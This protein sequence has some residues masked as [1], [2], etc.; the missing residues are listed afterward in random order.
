[1]GVENDLTRREF[2]GKMAKTTAA[3]AVAGALPYLGCS[4]GRESADTAFD[5]IVKGGTVYDGTLSK[6]IVADIGIEGDKITAI[7]TL[8]QKEAGYE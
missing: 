7:G 1:M 6:P 4:D 3:V 5:V 8:D 2:V